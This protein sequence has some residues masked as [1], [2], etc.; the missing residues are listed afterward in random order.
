[1]F[2]DLV[3][4]N[5]SYRRF[6]ADERVEHKTLVGLVEAARYTPSACNFQNIRYFLVE[7]KELC[8]KVFSSLR[9]AGYLKDWDGPEIS[10]RPSAYIVLMS[11]KPADTL[12]AIDL[13]IAAQTI[14]LAAASEGLGG[15]MFRGFDRKGLAS[16]VSVEGYS[17]ELVI[18]LGRPAERVEI[19]DIKNGDVKYY[20][21]GASTHFVPKRTLDELIISESCAD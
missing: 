9:F 21:D 10:E 14:L 2:L 1:M 15:C 8:D 18:A 7:E 5:R 16:A 17:P 19:V 11:A 20:R 13:G 12:L 6:H 3:K 4:K